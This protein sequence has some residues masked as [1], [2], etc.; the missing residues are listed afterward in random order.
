MARPPQTSGGFTSGK[1]RGIVAS[2]RCCRISRRGC[3]SKSRAPPDFAVIG[4]AAQ[5][6]LYAVARDVDPAGLWLG[7]ERVGAGDHRI[8]RAHRDGSPDVTVSTQYRRLGS[9]AAAC[10]GA[11]RA[12]DLFRREK[13]TRPSTWA[14]SRRAQHMEL[15]IAEMNMFILL[16][17]PELS[18]RST[19]SGSSVGTLYDH[20]IER[21]PAMRKIRANRTRYHGA[22]DAVGLRRAEGCAHQSIATPLIGRRRMV[23]VVRAG[24]RS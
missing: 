20:F 9:T 15:G 5:P 16:S 3:R 6:R 10:S 14:F 23:L 8:G 7:A 13:I 22:S 19:A 2:S 24:L 11:R 4:R 17:A 12:A 21:G 1:V 18:T